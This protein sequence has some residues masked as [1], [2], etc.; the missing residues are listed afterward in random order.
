MNNQKIKELAVAVYY[1]MRQQ[2]VSHV[3]ALAIAIDFAISETE[4]RTPRIA[5][6]KAAK[7][8]RAKARK[9]KG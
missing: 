5:P 4:H 8:K 6:A 7:N 9:P 2:N 1:N 3:M